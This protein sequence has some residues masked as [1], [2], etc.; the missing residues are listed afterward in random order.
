MAEEL[1]QLSEAL[2]LEGRDVDTGILNIKGGLS[3]ALGDW[4]IKTEGDGSLKHSRYE[5]TKKE[6]NK[7]IDYDIKGRSSILTD[8][9]LD[10]TGRRIFF[11]DQ[12]GHHHTL[13]APAYT[14]RTG[15]ALG[16]MDGITALLSNGRVISAHMTDENAVKFPY[17]NDGSDTLDCT[18]CTFTL[19]TSTDNRIIHK[20]YYQ[21][22]APTAG[23]KMQFTLEDTLG[24]LLYENVNDFEFE[25]G[26]GDAVIDGENEHIMS[27]EFRLPIDFNVIVTVRF[28]NS[29]NVQGD[30]TTEFKFKFTI[31]ASLVHINTVLELPDWNE[32][33]LRN[34]GVFTKDDWIF[35]SGKVYTCLVTGPQVDDFVSNIDKWDTLD[36][37][38]IS[39]A[40]A[41]TGIIKGGEISIN[42]TDPTK[43][44]I[45][46]GI[47]IIVNQNDM[48]NQIYEVIPFVGQTIDGG[49]TPSVTTRWIGFNRT[50]QSTGEI[51]LQDS[52]T[53]TDKRTIAVIGRI[54]NSG[55]TTITGK[56]QYT[57]TSYGLEKTVDDLSYALGALNIKGNIFTPNGVNLKL[58][59]SSGE[60]F[61]YG[62]NFNANSIS[63]NIVENP[64]IQPQGTYRYYLKDG[65]EADIETDIQPTMWDNNGILTAVA[66]QK[67]TIQPIYYYPVSNVV[68]VYYGQKE[69]GSLS[70]AKDGI[71]DAIVVNDIKLSGSI[72]RGWIVVK[73]EC[74]E[75]NDGTTAELVVATGISGGSSGSGSSEVIDDLTPQL[76]GD[77]DLNAKRV[78]NSVTDQILIDEKVNIKTP[79]S[80]HDDYF[81]ITG[82]SGDPVVI[83]L[84]QVGTNNYCGVSFK[85]DNSEHF[86]T[87][88]TD[89]LDKFVIRNALRN[90]LVIDSSGKVGIG[91]D[92]P[93]V[94]L[95]V[96]DDVNANVSLL[97]QNGNGGS[98]VTND[99][100]ISN[101]SGSIA[102]ITRIG[103]TGKGYASTGGFMTNH[104]FISAESNIDGL[105]LVTRKSTAPIRFYTG[106]HANQ[107]MI[108]NNIGNLGIGI[109]APTQKLHV[110]SEIIDS[111]VI[112]SENSHVTGAVSAHIIA[113]TIGGD[114]NVFS[115]SDAM[116][117]TLMGQTGAGSVGILAENSPQ[118]MLIGTFN[119]VPLYLGTNNTTR[120]TI[121]NNGK[122]GIGT[123][124][125]KSKLTIES[126]DNML[127]N[128]RG[129]GAEIIL[130]DGYLD[131]AG[132]VLH[133]GEESGVGIKSVIVA[134]GRASGN[135]SS[136]LGFYTQADGSSDPIE[137]MCITSGRNVGIGIAVPL[138]KLHVNGS[139][140]MDGPLLCSMANDATSAI[141]VGEILTFSSSEDEHVRRTTAAIDERVL[142]V[143][144]SAAAINSTVLMACGG[145]FDVIINNTVTRGDFLR[146]S[147][148]AGR[149]ESSGTGGAAGDF[150]IAMSSGTIGQT[151]KA[152]FKKCEIY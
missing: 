138:G 79:A 151:I 110:H 6:G 83:G 47:A 84:D 77:L 1:R 114:A 81:R 36:S 52:F 32:Y 11:I 34:S 96:Q 55:T 71:S 95:H 152:R 115:W 91:T 130:T 48:D 131:D 113:R 122:I 105:N 41:Y 127:C 104:G 125:P 98:S 66:N 60:S 76:G 92:S 24:N 136:S 9:G 3:P 50:G 67:W 42:V 53:H 97:F 19:P 5:K 45:T 108:L 27:P 17:F 100:Q 149:A 132:L 49:L 22:N 7:W 18:E 101:G 123:D 75:L 147:A 88:L 13:I 121:L 39:K 57:S 73:K 25:S 118:R 26:G 59:K 126:S 15:V 99:V 87:G 4:V 150:A 35:E 61:R 128:I 70:E 140:V 58:D 116:A 143:A 103:I 2:K 145:T 142:G 69:Y 109:A 85:R 30:I 65:L 117:G 146:S 14:D 20:V 31:E 37:V 137:A 134:T 62:A 56:G 106:G 119:S 63:P 139:T 111:P 90:H 80:S 112:V 12:D 74:D 135:W 129:T 40:S 120:M 8:V 89:T 148:A 86:F 28:S 38:R 102:D 51:I 29:I 21:A 23:T 44:D 93:D 82:D 141:V 46:A 107:R 33:S 94:N 144:A 43:F 64:L 124:T 10:S 16:N 72:L 68:S 133:S 54:W 78:F